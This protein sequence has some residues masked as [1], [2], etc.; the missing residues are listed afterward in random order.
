MPVSL[1]PRPLASLPTERLS[2]GCPHLDAALS[3][4]LPVGS[5]TEVAGEQGRAMS[6]QPGSGRPPS[7]ELAAA[8]AAR[9]PASCA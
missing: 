6:I 4:G 1:R 7:P 2:T 9:P 3:G 8:A 5:L